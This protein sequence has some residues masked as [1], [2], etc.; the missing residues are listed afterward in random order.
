LFSTLGIPEDTK[1]LSSQVINDEEFLKQAAWVFQ[2]ELRMLEYGLRNF[3]SGVLFF[4]LGRI[5]QLSH[6]FWSTMDPKHPAYEEN[7]SH[8]EV[9][10]D[11]YSEIDVV[12]GTI[13][14]Q[15]DDQTTLLVMS[16]H[17][18]APFYRSFHLNSWLRKEGYISL[19]DF[20]EGGMLRNVNWSSTRAHGFGFN[21][22]YI[23][24]YG[25]E[26]RGIVHSGNDKRILLEEIS[27]K[28]LKLHDPKSGRVVVTQ[29]LPR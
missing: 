11:A 25:R 14:R 29:S 15:I 22:L 20:S 4:Y 7:S 12:L 1:A 10:R 6:M 5:D 13:M 23:N 18:F 26:P 2:E 21:G 24:L 8:S 16:N 28:L 27:S 9:I 19:I 17:G 3:Q